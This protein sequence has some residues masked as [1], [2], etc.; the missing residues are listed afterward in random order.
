MCKRLAP[1]WKHATCPTKIKLRILIVVV[2]AQLLY[3]T[4]SMWFN[5]GDCRRLDTFFYQ[6]QRQILKY[7]N[8][9]VDRTKQTNPY[10]QKLTGD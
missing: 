4:P 1:L 9:F 7:E 6:A 10:A 5:P 3:S 2:G 8:T